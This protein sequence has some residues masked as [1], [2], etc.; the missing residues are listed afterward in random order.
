[1]N[2]VHEQPGIRIYQGSCLDVLPHLPAGSVNCCVTSPPYWGLRDYG[3]RGQLGLEATPA[4]YVANMVRV[5]REVRRVLADDGTLWLNLGDSYC[6]SAT[7]SFNGGSAIFAGRDLSGHASATVDK[8]KVPG[9]K[10]KDLVGI[11]WT[12]ALA[13]RDSGWWLRS[14]VIWHK[15]AVMPDST[16]DRPTRDH[17]HLFLLA[18]SARYFYDHEAVAEPVAAA[19]R[20]DRVDT[21]RFRPDRGYPGSASGGNGRLGD[22]ETRNV[23]TVWKISAKPYP[24]A[25][26]ATF[27]PE[28]PERC[29]KAGCPVGGTV[30]DPFHGSGT[31]MQV[32]R[33]LGRAYVGVELNP[34]Y[35]E[36]SKNRVRQEVL[37]G[38][39][40]AA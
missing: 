14:E 25:H 5:F 10:P 4:E 15:P 18:K 24:G 39:G 33:E 30:L 13:L 34:A 11:P 21:G 36:L 17:E 26:F 22:K 40:G 27:P 35:I 29:I 8:S 19:T 20:N 31:T 7:G 38:I 37:F 28:L 9:L 2:P 32:A 6:A 12:V 3:V 1:M 16:E 23:R